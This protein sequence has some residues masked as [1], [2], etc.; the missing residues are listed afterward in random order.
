MKLITTGKYKGMY[1]LKV[2]YAHTYQFPDRFAMF[3]LWSDYFK[4]R[5]GWKHRLDY[6][7]YLSVMKLY[8]KK[9]TK[10]LVHQEISGFDLGNAGIIEIVKCKAGKNQAIINWPETTRRGRIIRYDNEH[11]NGFYFTFKWLFNPGRC[12]L[13]CCYTFRA[14]KHQN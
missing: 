11:T 10:K 1:Q 13:G 3:N 14:E 6:K 4:Q 2:G 9:M 12:N 5:I 8:I 7:Q